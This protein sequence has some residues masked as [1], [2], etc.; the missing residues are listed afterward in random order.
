M[1]WVS[2][3]LY[4]EDIKPESIVSFSH[5][6]LAYIIV[7]SRSGVLAAFIDECSHQ[8]VPLSEFGE[9]QG[10]VLVCHAH[11]AC[12]GLGSN[13]GPT[14][15]LLAGPARDPLKSIPIRVDQSGF[16]LLKLLD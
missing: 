5:L 13:H 10:D 12:F 15:C 1:S 16:I 7:R 3:K 8:P 4:A 9:I 2:T 14:G 6:S 11:G